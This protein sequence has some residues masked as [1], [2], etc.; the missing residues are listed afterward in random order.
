[1]EY[2]KNGMM[3]TRIIPTFHYSIKMHKNYLFRVGSI[4]IE[5]SQPISGKLKYEYRIRNIEC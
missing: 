5:K 4:L 3:E 2:W 1:M